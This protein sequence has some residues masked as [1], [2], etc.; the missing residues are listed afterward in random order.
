MPVAVVTTIGSA[1]TSAADAERSGAARHTTRASNDIPRD[2][3]PTR[4]TVAALTGRPSS[5][6]KASPSSE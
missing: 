4:L 1:S 2:R 6:S 3:V 5:G